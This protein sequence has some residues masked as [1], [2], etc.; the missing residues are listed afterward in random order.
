MTLIH[1]PRDNLF[2]LVRRY[3]H[4]HSLMEKFHHPRDRDVDRVT[5][6]N[7]VYIYIYIPLSTHTAQ[8]HSS[9]EEI[10]SPRLASPVSISY[11]TAAHSQI[12]RHESRLSIFSV[13]SQPRKSGEISVK[14]FHV[15]VYSDGDG[16]CP[17]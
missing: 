17:A 2:I 12:M 8:I 10:S 13:R 5:D 11:E 16:P 7:I 15:I 14:R 6:R 3:Y 9:V 4:L 1:P